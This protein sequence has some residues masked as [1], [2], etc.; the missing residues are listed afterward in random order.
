MLGGAFRASVTLSMVLGARRRAAS[1]GALGQLSGGRRK[2]GN[3]DLLCVRLGAC[4]KRAKGEVSW[5]GPE[6]DSSG[7]TG[8]EEWRAG[9]GY[10]VVISRY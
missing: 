1:A 4:A 7:Q 9:A 2:G 8:Q 5:E 3:R 10:L 6:E